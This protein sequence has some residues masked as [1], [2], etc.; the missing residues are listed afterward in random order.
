MSSPQNAPAPNPQD[1]ELPVPDSP[2]VM[3][4]F[5][6]TGDLSHHKLMPSLFSLFRQKLLPGDFSII[7]FSRRDVSDEE[8]RRSFGTLGAEAGWTEFAAH[9][10]YQQ[11]LFEEEQGYRALSGKLARFDARSGGQA[12]IIL[13]LATPPANYEVI[14]A[15]IDS[16]LMSSETGSNQ[17]TRVVVEKPF[18]EDLDTARALDKTCSLKFEEKQIFRVDHYLGKETVQNILAFRFANGIFEPAWNRNYIDHVQITWSEKK[19]VEGRGKVFDEMGLLR[20]IAQNHLMQLIAAVAME[21]PTSFVNEDIRDA[22][23]NAIRSIRIIEPDNVSRYTVRGQYA[24]Y[25]DEKDVAP[26]STTETFVALQ[27]FV[28]TPRFAGVPFYVRAGKKMPR[29]VVEISIFF[30]QTCHVLFKEYGCPE[31]GNVITIRIQP[32]EGISIRFVAKKPGV[33]LALRMSTLD[34]SYSE[35]FEEQIADAYERI[36]LDI[37]RG[38]PTHCSRSDELD[39]SWEIITRILEGWSLNTAPKLLKYGAG[40]WGPKEAN[41]MIERDGRSWLQDR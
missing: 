24:S 23:F 17:R 12:T 4:I 9:L 15:N 1:S 32:D 25:H 2:F 21:P 22:R 19:G 31:A 6:V 35:G 33:K 39:H 11:G 10:T 16:I 27:L 13:Y 20:D 26:D 36:L 41:E 34:F 38:D 14:L 5:G 29:D 8:L 40:E 3:V 28:D 7:G 37:L 30:I 18:G